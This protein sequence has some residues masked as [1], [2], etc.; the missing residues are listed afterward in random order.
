MDRVSREVERLN[1]I[2]SIHKV[3]LDHSSTA[4]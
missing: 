2:H 1:L 4:A 3:E